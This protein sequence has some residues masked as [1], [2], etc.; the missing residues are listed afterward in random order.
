MK[1]FLIF[2]TKSL[3]TLG[4]RKQCIKDSSYT[5]KNVL[6]PVL[7]MKALEAD[8]KFNFQIY[9]ITNICK[10]Y[11]FRNYIKTFLFQ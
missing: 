6:Y 4:Q 2:R 11:V 3:Y 5:T 7:E 1:F 8:A 9:I 10:K